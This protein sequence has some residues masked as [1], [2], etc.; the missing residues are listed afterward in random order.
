MSISCHLSGLGS[1]TPPTSLSNK[2][3]ESIVE[4]SDEW[5]R[6]RTGIHSRHV[7]AEGE[8]PTDLATEAAKRAI[9][10]SGI[11]MDELTHI[12][13]ATCTPEWLCPGDACLITGKIG[14]THPVMAFDV[15]AA[16]SGFIYAL[17]VARGIVATRPNAKVLTMGVE[18]LTRRMNWKDRGT[19]ILFGDGAGATVVTGEKVAGAGPRAILDDIECL[20]DGRHWELLTIG[21]GSGRSYV[22]GESVVDDDFYIKM[23]GSD[24]FKFAVRNMS[25]ICRMLLDRNGLTLD[26]VDLM[27]P[28]QANLRIIDAVRNRLGIDP[29]KIFVNIE[30]MGNTSAASIPLALTEAWENGRLRPG[31]RV[32]LVTF[33]GGFTWA[34]ALLR[35]E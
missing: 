19:C 21:G 14:L 23:A 6:E 4:T 11:T 13:L 10:N 5:I 12:V 27:V 34:A 18:A 16:C 7:L 33:G 29:A 15:N 9:A 3:M 22:A 2:E 32:L 24:V 26:D 25:A 31:M 1:C 8:K 20:S 28:H 30:H 35:F 17:D